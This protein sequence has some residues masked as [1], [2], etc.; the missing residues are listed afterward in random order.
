MAYRKLPRD[1]RTRITDYFEH[2]YQGK[3]FN[4][5]MILDELSERLREV[6]NQFQMINSFIK[7]S[8]FKFVFRML[9]IIT[10]VRSLHQ[11][12]SFLMLILI[13]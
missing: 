12:H 4:E 10:V 2:R 11:F 1:L 8:N 7:I 3:F 5:E 6:R 9:L 13:L